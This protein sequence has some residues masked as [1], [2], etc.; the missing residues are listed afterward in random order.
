MNQEQYK[1]LMEKMVHQEGA[2]YWEMFN[3][4]FISACVPS[5]IWESEHLNFIIKHQPQLEEQVRQ[6]I[7][8]KAEIIEIGKYKLLFITKEMWE[9]N[10]DK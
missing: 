4:D 9:E 3:E 2:M 7:N 10:N 5:K 6:M 8:D 1:I